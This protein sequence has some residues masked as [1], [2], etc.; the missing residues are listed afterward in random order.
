M[1]RTILGVPIL[2]AQHACNQPQEIYGTHAE[3]CKKDNHWIERHDGVRYVAAGTLR[4]AGIRVRLEQ[5]TG[6]TTAKRGADLLLTLPGQSKKVAVD[7]SIASSM[8]ADLGARLSHQL[9]P[10]GHAAKQR[11]REKE[12]KHLAECEESG[13]AFEPLCADAFGG[14]EPASAACIRKWIRQG[15]GLL[16]EEED[17][18]GCGV[19]RNFFQEA[20]LAI[21]RAKA[22]GILRRLP[23]GSTFVWPEVVSNGGAIPVDAVTPPDL[24]DNVEESGA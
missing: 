8:K 19:T 11:R 2:D 10:G 22:E 20:S 14:W 16:G 3:L 18:D 1:L 21:W 9:R 12:I 24:G 17:E 13:F 23:A 5:R 15:A 6:T 7:I 4:R